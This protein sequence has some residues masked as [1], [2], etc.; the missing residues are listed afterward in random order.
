MALDVANPIAAQYRLID[1]GASGAVS[2]GY[3]TGGTDLGH[4]LSHA[5]VAMSR[6]VENEVK[7]TSGTHFVDGSFMGENLILEVVLGQ[8]S[9]DV[10]KLGYNPH[11]VSSNSGL[12]NGAPQ[13]KLGHGVKRSGRCTRLLVRP[14]K[15]GT[16]PKALVI[17]TTRPALLLPYA[18]CIKVGPV[19]YNERG[20]LMEAAVLTIVSYW[21]ETNGLNRYWGDVATF[22]S[23]EGAPA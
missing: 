13:I 7:Q 3:N 22:P 14:V 4:V 17:D 21:D 19:Q 10:L 18:Y 2:G 20:K 16:N 8:R 6:D 12:L 9:S 5:A 11:W 23:I 1:L 15:P